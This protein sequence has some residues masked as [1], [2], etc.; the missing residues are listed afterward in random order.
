MGQ[1]LEVIGAR[2]V[3]A[4]AQAETAMTPNTGNSFTVRDFPDGASAFLF[5]PVVGAAGLSRLRIR[6]PRLHD[7]AQSIR[8]VADA[9]GRVLLAG[10]F[11][12]PLEPN[13]PL[14]V[15]LSSSAAETDTAAYHV[16]Y[17]DLPGVSARLASVADVAP[18]VQNIHGVL[19][20]FAVA[21]GGDWSGQQAINAD[22]DSLKADTDYAIL[23]ATMD[24]AVTAV[25]IQG[26]DLGNMGVGIPG[27]LD[28][29][30][31]SRWFVDLSEWTGRPCIPVINS[32][33][34]G[35]VLVDAMNAAAVAA[36][37]TTIILAELG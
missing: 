8:L 35:T 27:A 6:S 31:S 17:T 36:F 26:V 19:N 24:V 28:P 15:E 7:A 11:Q 5:A 16:Y 37:N 23:G 18:R 14:I 13:D 3:A 12:Q 20:T 30:E 1:A 34:R 2:I 10:E 9:S 22:Q 21:V 29:K 4:G 25:R 32:N 33:N